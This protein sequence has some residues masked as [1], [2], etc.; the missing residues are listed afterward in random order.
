[1][2]QENYCVNI[3]EFIIWRKI[4][5]LIGAVDKNWGIGKDNKLLV[6]IPNDMK[7][8]RELTMNKIIITGRKTMETF[9]NG[10][11]LM[12]RINIMLTRNH[13]YKMKDVEVVHSVDEAIEK[14]NDL[15]K[16]GYTS[17]D[18]F[19]IGGQSIYNQFISY[20]DTAYITKIDCEYEAEKF[21]PN[22][23]EMSDW[24]LVEQSDEQTYFSL[25]Y[26]FRKY[27]KIG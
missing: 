19:V 11:P 15:Y 22:I 6:S 9:Q 21:C 25:E 10:N 23:E 8:F 13:D 14:L 24:Q 1:M 12:N 4:M 20:C 7:H 26:D 5:N 27:R 18:V 3:C 2:Y 17:D 16:T